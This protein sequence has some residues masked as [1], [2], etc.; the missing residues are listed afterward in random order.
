MYS[1]ATKDVRVSPGVEG[2]GDAGS[3][4]MLLLG[5]MIAGPIYLV[6]GTA[7]AM[8]RDG[9][10]LMRHS[11][12]VLANGPG[13]WVQVVNFVVAGLLVVGGAIGLRR[14]FGRK[15]RRFTLFLGLYGAGMLIAAVFRADPVDGF[16]PGTPL[17]PPTTF[18]TAGMIH[19]LAGTLGFI[20]LAIACILAGRMLKRMG[21]PGLARLSL[22]SG[23]MVI[24]GFFGGAAFAMS[25]GVLAIWFAV[26]VGWTWLAVVC[27]RARREMAPGAA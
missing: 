27:M 13:G 16:P 3:T 26:I 2:A 11:L 21:Q 6:T 19:F 10:D 4:R 1:N 22:V 7:Q 8:Y 5:G 23:Q 14:A 15:A 24:V 12:S 25:G 9:F 20:S 17:G 18:T